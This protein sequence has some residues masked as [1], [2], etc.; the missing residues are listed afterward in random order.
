MLPFVVIYD[1]NTTIGAVIRGIA[2]LLSFS[3]AGLSHGLCVLES[4]TASEKVLLECTVP[5]LVAAAMVLLVGLTSLRCPVCR[6]FRGSSLEF[7][8]LIQRQQSSSELEECDD[9]TQLTLSVRLAASGLSLMLMV[10][11]TL[12]FGAAKLL[13]C[14]HVPGFAEQRL[15]IQGSA[16][17]NYGEWQSPYVVVFV[18]LA[19]LPFVLA[20][21][22]RW[23]VASSVMQPPGKRWAYLAKLAIRRA[24]VSPYTSRLYWWESV[25]M[26]H[27][28]LLVAAFTF[29][30]SRPILQVVVAVV[31][32]SAFM[33]VHVFCRPMRDGVIQTMQSVLLA[34]L[35][36]A[37]LGGVLSAARLSL[38]SAR[39]DAESQRVLD[40]MEITFGFVV[41]CVAF[42]IASGV[43]C[44]RRLRSSR[45]IHEETAYQLV[46]RRL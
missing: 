35:S 3:T 21:L 16:V 29:L 9:A 10:Y 45:G 13:H 32:C 18:V 7:T 39:K 8:P 15:F 1:V 22:T 2:S 14:V 31:I 24:V 26:L 12:L 36:L 41:P 11:A 33:F 28:L 17:C 27:R 19:A 4:M 20:A 43:L 38:G 25:L 40:G 23:S 5:F 46:T 30:S 34:C 37:A 42:L 6:S 44:L